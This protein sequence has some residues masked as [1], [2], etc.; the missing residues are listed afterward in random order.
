[1]PMFQE[2]GCP[3]WWRYF[4]TAFVLIKF[5]CDVDCR[6]IYTVN[7][8]PKFCNWRAILVA[9]FCAYI[10]CLFNFSLFLS[11]YLACPLFYK[12]AVLGLEGK[13]NLFC[14]IWHINW[15]GYCQILRLTFQLHIQLSLLHWPTYIDFRPSTP[16]SLA[17]L[18]AGRNWLRGGSLHCYKA[19]HDF[20]LHRPGA[21]DSF[22]T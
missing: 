2:Y 1:M 16:C 14:R 11:L 15:A 10:F 9:F 6:Y 13:K 21:A 12:M 20:L 17:W 19:W 4:S 3:F 18:V 5:G 22:R 8:L 7:F